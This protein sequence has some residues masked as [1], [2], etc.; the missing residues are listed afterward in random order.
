[1][2]QITD[3]VAIPDEEVTF[4]T[5]RSGGPGG[6]NVNKLETRVTLRFDLAA[7]G[8]LTEEQKA[9]LLE[10]LATRITRA[11]IL[12]VS[13]QKHRTQGANRDA[14]LERFAELVR[15]ALREETPR[16]KT[17]TSR[18]AKARRV[19]EKRR[20][21]ERKRNRSAPVPID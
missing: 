5:S 21:S 20:H 9:R 18:A 10:R 15:D 12:H 17:R 2:I 1:M 16:K 14:A 13:A 8:S 7:S 19:E 6:Q 4:A 3:D 11:G